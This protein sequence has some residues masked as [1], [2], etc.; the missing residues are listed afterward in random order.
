MKVI[1][2]KVLTETTPFTGYNYAIVYHNEIY[3]VTNST[4][5]KFNHITK[6]F[7]TIYTFTSYT[8]VGQPFIDNDIL[9]IMV[10]QNASSLTGSGTLHLHSYDGTTFTQDVKT[11]TFGREMG[12][13]YKTNTSQIKIYHYSDYGASYLVT[14]NLTI[15]DLTGS[16]NQRNS[17]HSAEWE[18][19]YNISNKVYTFGGYNGLS[20]TRQNKVYIDYMDANVECYESLCKV[21]AVVDGDIILTG[22]NSGN[23]N[24]YK[25][26]VTSNSITDIN[27]DLKQNQYGA[28][29]VYIDNAIYIFGGY[30][31]SENVSPVATNMIQVI[32]FTDY[33]LT[34]NFAN[35][36]GETLASITNSAP[37]ESMR[38]NTV[39]SSVGVILNTMGGQI[40]AN[41]TTVEPSGYKLVGYGLVQ[42]GTRVV[43]PV[44]KLVNIAVT[45]DTT[46]YEIYAKYTPIDT[47][48]D[49]VLYTNT[50]ETNRVDKTNFLTTIA[51]LKGTLREST[52]ILSPSIKIVVDSLPTFN[53][54]YIQAF[55]SRYYF[56]TN[57]TSIRQ[58]LWQIDLKCDVLMTYKTD[59]LTQSAIINRTADS[60]YIDKTLTDNYALAKAIPTVSVIDMTTTNAEITFNTDD[61]GLRLAVCLCKARGEVITS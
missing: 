8:H 39:G 2:T 40:T 31:K 24:I 61:T 23:K 48:I 16:S 17:Y 53:Y 33:N 49:I 32:E 14:Y 54:C 47:P 7:T 52:S 43:I 56:V 10:F 37:I 27:V 34:F 51:T 22:G 57:I 55:G 41:Y 36:Q 58:N 13:S 60:S 42:G 45:T 12:M 15:P 59:I 25:Y 46:F 1:T 20:Y 19:Y 30:N 26:N 3:I 21:G 18:Q 38:V 5:Y 35:S 50:A 28:G 4:L 6:T 9:Y 29:T 44:N 11:R